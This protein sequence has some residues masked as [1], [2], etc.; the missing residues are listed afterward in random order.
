MPSGDELLC[1]FYR[2]PPRILKHR[3]P[4]AGNTPMP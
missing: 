2:L 4:T 3:F 1:E